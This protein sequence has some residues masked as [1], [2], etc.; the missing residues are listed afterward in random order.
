[1]L[2]K[3]WLKNLIKENK[4]KSYEEQNK[5]NEINKSIYHSKNPLVTSQYQTK[6]M[7]FKSF[8]L[9]REDYEAIKDY[10][11]KVLEYKNKVSE[12]ISKN[13]V[14]FHLKD[15]YEINEEIAK[16]DYVYK[17]VLGST[18]IRKALEDVKT[19]Y[20]TCL[21]QKIKNYYRKHSNEKVFKGRRALNYLVG[22]Y[23]PT[24]KFRLK[25]MNPEEMKPEQKRALILLNY[26][27]LRLLE[28]INKNRQKLFFNTKVTFRSLTFT[29]CGPISSYE[30]LLIN[31]PDNYN[32][33]HPNKKLR[34]SNKLFNMSVGTIKNRYVVPMRVNIGKNDYHTQEKFDSISTSFTGGAGIPSAK[35]YLYRVKLDEFK[36]EIEIH[37]AI[38]EKVQVIPDKSQKPI[39][40]DVNCKHNIY[41]TSDGRFYNIEKSIKDKIIKEHKKLKEL[42]NNKFKRYENN[43]K[44]SKTL[45]KSQKIE[46][47]KEIKSLRK[48]NKEERRRALKNDRRKE[49]QKNYLASKLCKETK[50]LGYDSII[51]EDL[52]FKNRKNHT[53][54]EEYDLNYNDLFGILRLRCLNDVVKRIGNRPKYN[55]TVSIVNPA[56]TSQQCSCCGYVSGNNRKTQEEFKCQNCGFEHNADFN[57]SLNILDRFYDDKLTVLENEMKE[58]KK[59]KIMKY[60]EIKKNLND[61]VTIINEKLK[62]PKSEKK[63]KKTKTKKTK[64]KKS[65]IT[66]KFKN[67]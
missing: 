58:T 39:G 62:K 38:K 12:V 54:I 56:Y 16:L 57:A 30:D 23:T 40:V 4:R 17:Y 1:M 65:T 44:N 15:M 53:R 63:A 41:S 5:I 9:E 46:K 59:P 21:K 20:K 61:R 64:T 32:K 45:S 18:N 10:A 24:L 35:Q 60:K 47:L 42:K 6:S 67:K 34:R 43:I 50:T 49:F 52:S 51:M 22:N 66:K 29:N 28:T 48:F 36:K 19:K 25:N 31:N 11:L 26:D 55:L 8:G 37:F 7:M 13:I 27:E 3:E 33:N 2:S 14:N